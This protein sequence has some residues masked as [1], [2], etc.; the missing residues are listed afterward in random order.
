M[1]RNNNLNQEEYK[2]DDVDPLEHTNS[3]W[4][5][6]SKNLFIPN[7]TKFLDCKDRNLIKTITKSEIDE[8]FCEY[9]NKW[10]FKNYRKINLIDATRIMTMNFDINTLD[11]V[12]RND[13]VFRNKIDK[14]E[15]DLNHIMNILDDLYS[16]YEGDIKPENRITEEEFDKY[17]ERKNKIVETMY[18]SINAIDTLVYGIQTSS[19]EYD[20]SAS[21]DRSL[22]KYTSQREVQRRE[23]DHQKLLRILLEFCSR[24]NYS[25]Y[26]DLIYQPVY[27][28]EMYH[29]LSCQKVTEIDIF[30]YEQTSRDINPESWDLATKDKSNVKFVQEYLKN[31]VD[32]SLPNLE[33][34]RYLFSFDNGIYKLFV[35]NED[36]TYSDKFFP[37]SGEERPNRK[38]GMVSN[39]YF[40]QNF[41]NKDIKDWYD[42][43]TDNI[44]KILDLQYEHDKEYENICRWMYIMMGRLLYKIGE[45]DEWQ[46]ICFMKGLAG[47]GKGTITKTVQNFY[48]VEDVGVLGNDSEKTFGLSAIYDK[49]LFIAPEIKED[50]SLSQASFQSMISGEDVNVPIKHK[51]AVSITWEVP[52]ILA[53]NEVPNWTDNSGSIAR[54]L[55]IFAFNKKVPRSKLDPQLWNRIKKN[56]PNILRKCN[57]AYL[58][59][60]NKYASKN[61]WDILPNYFRIKQQ[62]ISEQT[63]ELKKFLKGPRVVY[64]KNY[65]I[66]EKELKE[67]FLAFL[68]DNRKTFNYSPDKLNEPFQTL[69]EEYNSEIKLTKIDRRLAKFKTLENDSFPNKRGDWIRGMTIQDSVTNEIAEDVNFVE[70]L[71][72]VDTL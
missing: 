16:N 41:D 7:K 34:D 70:Y 54:R 32:S 68:K 55:I 28:K 10:T 9:E 8:I 18:Y 27:T 65:Y 50:I 60:V 12:L 4:N 57:L 53:G 44:Q 51:T 46:V 29:T 23:K 67:H 63:N 72:F 5:N 42:I 37:Y 26:K 71:K 14:N 62:E 2:S 3:L 40:D 56:I 13:D 25:K 31:C 69:E 30:V 1:L 61:I 38:N 64:G 17:C 58:D 39:K 22:L 20:N 45:L 15:K 52:G 48:D 33:K 59:A 21:N 66:S 43:P 47:T 19:P 24:R 36:N 6:F 11:E 35:K 49:L